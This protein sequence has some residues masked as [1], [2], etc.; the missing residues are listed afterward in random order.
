[1]CVSDKLLSFFSLTICTAVLCN[2]EALLVFSPIEH[3]RERERE[4]CNRLP[5]TAIFAVFWGG[6]LLKSH[7]K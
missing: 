4:Q 5:Q 2:S 6:D 3:S 1:M 7:A